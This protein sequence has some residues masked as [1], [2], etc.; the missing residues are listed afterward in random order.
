MTRVYQLSPWTM[1]LGFLGFVALIFLSLPV[2]LVLASVF[3][4]AN[5]VR[6]V[7]RVP[8]ASRNSTYQDP[9]VSSVIQ[10]KKIGS[11]RIKKNPQDPTIIEVLD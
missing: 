11:Y 8:Q 5:L 3:L 9:N 4:I 2:V 1:L 7:L 10:N 6:R